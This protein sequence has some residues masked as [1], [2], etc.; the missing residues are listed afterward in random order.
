MDVLLRDW[1]LKSDLPGLSALFSSLK[2]VP[3]S[4]CSMSEE[5]TAADTRSLVIP[6]T[7]TFLE[8]A[9]PGSQG[10]EGGLPCSGY[11]GVS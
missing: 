9:R 5:L 1:P 4:Q 6:I 10:A 2:R 11:L 7:V 8:A 3:V